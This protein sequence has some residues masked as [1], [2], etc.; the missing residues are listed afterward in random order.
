[1]GFGES[2]KW[3]AVQQGSA[4]AAQEAGNI[5]LYFDDLLAKLQGL[6]D[7]DKKTVAGERAALEEKKTLVQAA[8]DTESGLSDMVNVLRPAP[9]APPLGGF[10]TAERF[11][12]PMKDYRVTLLALGGIVLALILMR[13]AYR[14]AHGLV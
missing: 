10:L 13:G 14:G 1:M 11:L 5:R 9:G 2:E 3:A 6:L 8:F 4:F 12:D 7:A